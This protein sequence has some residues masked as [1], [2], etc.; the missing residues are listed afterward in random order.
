[1]RASLVPS[2]AKE[3]WLR[4]KK[5]APFLTGADGVVVSSYR[6]RNRLA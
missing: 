1:M 6:L 2:F 3:G 4:L 5:M